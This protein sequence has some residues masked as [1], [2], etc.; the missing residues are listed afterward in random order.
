M[1]SYPGGGK[2]L[3]GTFK[4]VERWQS[5][6]LRCPKD[7]DEL[8]RGF[9]PLFAYHDHLLEGR[10]IP[11]ATVEEF[12]KTG[13]VSQF[14]GDPKDLMLLQGQRNCYEYLRERVLARDDLEA[15]LVLEVHRI[16]TSGTYTEPFYLV[17]GERPGELKKR[18][19]V[20]AVNAVGAA[21]RD[22]GRELDHLV[23]EVSGYCGSELLQVAAYFHCRFENIHP[24]AAGNGAT[25]RTMMNY[26]LMI[27]DHP[28][29][30]FFAE[31]KEE[32]L[33]CLTTYDQQRDP[34]PLAA[35]LEKELAKTWA[36]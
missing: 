16:L 3:N 21:A 23:E 1:L 5:H 24:F 29:V 13:A 11:L 12:F 15:S 17:N 8:L 6:Q 26:F 22:V 33:Q 27:R 18:D 30:V 4:A 36:E 7:L 14:S 32:Y 31:D 35:F 2:P 25:G 9:R 19:Y 10:E 20:T 34:R 28:P